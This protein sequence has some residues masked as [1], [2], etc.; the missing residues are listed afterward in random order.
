MCRGGPTTEQH[1]LLC[2]LIQVKIRGANCCFQQRGNKRQRE[3][4]Y[5]FHTSTPF[6]VPPYQP[7]ESSLAETGGRG[8]KA[9]RAGAERRRRRRRREKEKK[10]GKKGFQWEIPHTH[11]TGSRKRSGQDFSIILSHHSR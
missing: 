9:G 3:S 6:F 2:W 4:F 5:S 7:G 1:L 8:G 11:Q 10:K